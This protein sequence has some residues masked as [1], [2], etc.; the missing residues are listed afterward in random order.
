MQH[1]QGV[2][3]HQQAHDIAVHHIEETV[4]EVVG[5][6]AAYSQ[7]HSDTSSPDL[8]RDQTPLWNNDDNDENMLDEQHVLLP[9]SV[10][11]FIVYYF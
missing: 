3:L 7:F 1:N 5:R 10:I 2:L 9:S 4:D 6:S 11:F 8:N